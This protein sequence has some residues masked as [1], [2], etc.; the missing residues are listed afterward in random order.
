[1]RL[2][3]LPFAVATVAGLALWLYAG[4]LLVRGPFLGGR[5]L[6]LEPTPLLGTFGGF[7]VGIIVF[8]WGAVR[9]AGVGAR[10]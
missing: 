5:P 4:Y 3:N 7:L 1:M 6:P 9:L 8:T 10:F 2:V